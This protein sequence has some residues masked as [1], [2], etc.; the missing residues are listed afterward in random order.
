MNCPFCN[1]DP[2]EYVDTGVGMMPVA[3]TCCDLGD[4]YFRGARPIPEDVTLPWDEFVMVGQLLGD[5]RHKLSDTPADTAGRT[6]PDGFVMVPIEPTLEM[7]LAAHG[8]IPSEYKEFKI[9]PIW[10]AMLK[11]SKI[12]DAD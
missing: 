9:L 11:A 6:L 8:F 4:V 12:I 1:L 10:K 3:V 2:F 5:L 7:T